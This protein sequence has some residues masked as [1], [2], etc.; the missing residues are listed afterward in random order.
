M[1]KMVS[2]YPSSQVSPCQLRFYGCLSSIL[3][4]FSAS[5]QFLGSKGAVRPHLDVFS[6]HPVK[7][8]IILKILIQR[9][10]TAVRN[11]IWPR[12]CQ[13]KDSQHFHQESFSLC[14]E[15]YIYIAYT[16]YNVYNMYGCWQ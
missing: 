7:N 11:S 2:N 14:H 1:Q 16:Y 8:S 10:Q 6:F 9:L 5:I 15:F 13:T 3:Q 12:F 4:A